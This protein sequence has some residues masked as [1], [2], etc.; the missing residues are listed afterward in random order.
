MTTD[1]CLRQLHASARACED[2]WRALR[3]AVVEDQPPTGGNA[4]VDRFADAV[5]DGFALCRDAVEAVDRLVELATAE[6]VGA[7]PSRLPLQRCGTALHRLG[8]RFVNDVWTLDRSWHLATLASSR[9]RDWNSWA[10]TVA[11][12]AVECERSMWRFGARLTPWLGVALEGTAASLRGT[13]TTRRAGDDPDDSET[14]SRRAPNVPDHTARG[15]ASEGRQPP[16]T[17]CETDALACRGASTAAVSP[18]C[19]DIRG[20][21]T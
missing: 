4:F 7:A 10:R 1:E 16:Q 18:R 6:P 5:E 9:R 21:S 11:E 2:C 20:I 17:R 12:L 13:A 14:A 15:A 3:L 19:N 8:E